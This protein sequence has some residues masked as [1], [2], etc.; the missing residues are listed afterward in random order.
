MEEDG[1]EAEEHEHDEAHKQ[2]PAHHCEVNP[3]SGR[4]QERVNLIFGSLDILHLI[5]LMSHQKVLMAVN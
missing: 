5:I 4:T 1:K 3:V 2:E